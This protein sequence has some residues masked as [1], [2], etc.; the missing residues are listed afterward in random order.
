MSLITYIGGY[1][2]F[3]TV[4]EAQIDA[5]ARGCTGSHTHTYKGMM[6]Y[7]ACKS[8]YDITNEQLSTF[9]ADPEPA[10]EPG[11]EIVETEVGET[12]DEEML[13]I[14]E[15]EEEESETAEDSRQ[16]GNSEDRSGDY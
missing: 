3:T 15:E 12:V 13:I 1:P 11:I 6:G 9:T 7:M 4:A 14:E 8:H 5:Q 2:L 10:V 16:E